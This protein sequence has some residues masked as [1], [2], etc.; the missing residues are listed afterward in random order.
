MLDPQGWAG[1]RYMLKKPFKQRNSNGNGHSFR[2]FSMGRGSQQTTI[3]VL[4]PNSLFGMTQDCEE[5]HFSRREWFWLARGEPQYPNKEF[6]LYRL[7]GGPMLRFWSELYMRE[8]NLHGC[9]A[10]SGVRGN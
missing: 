5:G 10:W 6:R 8:I 2:D 3:L 1:Y 4:P 7:V 9:T